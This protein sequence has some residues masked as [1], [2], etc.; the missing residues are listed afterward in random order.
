VF[1][2]KS[3]LSAMCELPSLRIS[4]LVDLT[5]GNMDCL[6]FRVFS[7]NLVSIR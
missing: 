4:S 5:S 7:F 6:P 1:F 2:I 3:L